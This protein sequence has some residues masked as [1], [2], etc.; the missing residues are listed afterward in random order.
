MQH[1]FPHEAPK[2]VL[3]SVQLPPTLHQ[4]G[5][6]QKLT[7][8]S[9]CFVLGV[10]SQHAPPMSQRRHLDLS[11]YVPS[12]PVNEPPVRFSF[13]QPSSTC[14][15]TYFNIFIALKQLSKVNTPCS[16]S[17][18]PLSAF[19]NPSVCCS[20][21]CHHSIKARTVVKGGDAKHTSGPILRRHLVSHLH[22]SPC[23]ASRRCHADTE[24]TYSSN[25]HQRVIMINCICQVKAK[26]QLS[27]REC[28]VW[29]VSTSVCWGGEERERFVFVCV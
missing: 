6:E 17:I 16:C 1:Y 15:L 8:C 11:N 23:A 25:Y 9:F 4:H 2:N 20:N 18:K 28:S 26:R 5:G 19:Y 27:T 3:W 7:E 21:S 10:F 14:V 24:C 12:N 13:C 22:P 29:C